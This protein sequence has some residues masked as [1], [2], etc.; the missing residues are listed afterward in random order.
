MQHVMPHVGL[1]SNRIQKNYEMLQAA[2]RPLRLG[3]HQHSHLSIGYQLF[4]S[5]DEDTVAVGFPLTH[6]VAVNFMSKTNGKPS[7]WLKNIRSCKLPK[8]SIQ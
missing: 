7:I 2:Q 8:K 4:M 5:S 1:E 3:I 6:L